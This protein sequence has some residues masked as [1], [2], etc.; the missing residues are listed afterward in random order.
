[1]R[2]GMQERQRKQHLCMQQVRIMVRFTPANIMWMANARVWF[3]TYIHACNLIWQHIPNTCDG[4]Y[5]TNSIACRCGHLS[6][7][8]LD[9]WQGEVGRVAV[10]ALVL[11]ELVQVGAQQLAHEEQVLLRAVARQWDGLV[12]TLEAYCRSDVVMQ[13]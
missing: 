5:E 3:R 9:A 13:D 11:L 4:S 12:C 10:V 8:G 1:M 2:L 6:C 7:N